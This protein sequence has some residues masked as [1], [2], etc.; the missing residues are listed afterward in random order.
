M[1]EGWFLDRK[2]EVPEG[3][4]PWFVVPPFNYHEVSIRLTWLKDWLVVQISSLQN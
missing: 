1:T 3:K 4:D 2:N